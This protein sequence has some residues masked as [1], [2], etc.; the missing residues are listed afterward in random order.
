MSPFETN[1]RNKKQ[2]LKDTWGQIKSRKAQIAIFQR[3][4]SNFILT[5]DSLRL[6]Y[7]Q[8]SMS[9]NPEVMYLMFFRTNLLLLL[10]WLKRN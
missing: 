3:N 9:Y 1:I 4:F 2:F 5:E 8:I 10:Q 6:A 7:T